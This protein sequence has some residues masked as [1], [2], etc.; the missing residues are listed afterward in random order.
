MASVVKRNRNGRVY[1]YLVKCARVNGKPRIVSQTYLG[2]SEKLANLVEFNKNGGIPDPDCS[3]VLEFGAVSALFDIAERLGIREIVNRHTNKR[4]QGLPVSDTVLLAAINRAVEPTSKK[5]F[6]HWFKKTTLNGMF[7][8]ANEKNLSSQAFWNNMHELDEEMIRLIEDDITSIIVSAYDINVECLLFDNTNFFSYIDTDTPSAL[9]KRGKS[10]QHRSDLRLI[11]L[12]LMVSPDHNI[13]LFHEAY[14]GNTNDAKRF[15]EVVDRLKA[16]YERLSN[17]SCSPTLILDRGNNSEENIKSILSS[18]PRQFHFVG[19][20]RFNQCPDMTS[21]P[22]S[23]F[24]PLSGEKLSGYT[25]IRK[26]KK[27]YGHDLTVV[28]TYNPELFKTQLDGVKMN[29]QKCEEKLAELRKSLLARSSGEVKK[30]KKPTVESVKKKVVGILSRQHMKNVF[31]TETKQ[32]EDGTTA[33]SYK[34]NEKKLNDLKKNVLGKSLL[35]TD[36]DDWSTEKIVSAYHAQYHVEQCFRQMKDVKYLSFRPQYH[37]T[38]ANVKVHAF[39]C[40]LALTLCSVLQLEMEE[41][42]HDMSIH[43]IIDTLNDVRQVITVFPIQ[44]GK[45]VTSKSS[46]AGLEGIAAEYIDKYDLRRY[47]L[48]SV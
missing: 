34:L 29:I 42:G 3:M 22:K 40:V 10:K 13:P 43:K 11:G 21:T 19:G 35:F 26:K 20:L 6:F 24:K 4:N 31:D 23:K 44:G 7:D 27:L 15:S 36:H 8:K 46:F 5:S 45:K 16:R 1:H 37:F 2:T 32:N 18:N 41:L 14:S 9:A 25:A 30:G 48:K 17:E 38:D 39:Y 28:L 12:T 33:F 47:A